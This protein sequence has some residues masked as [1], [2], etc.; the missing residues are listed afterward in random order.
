VLAH[1]AAQLAAIHVG[2]SDVEQ[3]QVVVGVL[4]RRQAVGRIG[5]LGGDELLV[6]LQLLGQGRAQR[7]VVVDQEDL[8]SGCHAVFPPRIAC[9]TDLNAPPQIM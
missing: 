9:V 4:D 2:Q 5:R 8:P 1:Q 7:V 3:D 6:E